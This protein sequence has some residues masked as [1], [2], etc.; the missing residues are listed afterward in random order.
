MKKKQS[1]LS[2]RLRKHYRTRYLVVPNG[3]TG[4]LYR[5]WIEDVHEGKCLA[6][7]HTPRDARFI[8]KA[9]NGGTPK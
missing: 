6:I 5:A 4:Y 2:A 8:A 9:L 1:G 3:K 7:C